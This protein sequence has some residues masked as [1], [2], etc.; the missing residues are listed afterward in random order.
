MRVP[1]ISY[2]IFFV[3]SG[4]SMANNCDCITDASIKSKPDTTI[5]TDS[6]KNPSGYY[7]LSDLPL[8]QVATLLLNDSL[9]PSDNNI[10]FNCMDSIATDNIETR[11]FYFPVFLKILDKADGALAEVV[12][13]YVVNY[14]EKYPKEFAIRSMALTDKEFISFAYSAGVELYFDKDNINN[15]RKWTDAVLKNCAGCDAQ[16]IRQIQ[17][18]NSTVV[19]AVIENN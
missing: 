8:R 1:A 6:L 4:N 2:L 9:H 13:M 5:I 19:Q 14:I 3:V 16:Q 17:R 18:F 12:G 11:N 10:T 15:S 7:Y